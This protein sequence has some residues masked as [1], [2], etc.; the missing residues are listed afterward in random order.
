MISS[1][2][3]TALVTPY[4]ADGSV[5]LGAFAELVS[6]QR[7]QGT[8]GVVVGGSTGESG[9]LERHEFE[10]LLDMALS[11]AR[12]ELWVIAGCGA[13]ATHKALELAR[14]AQRAGAAALLAVTPYYAR[15]TQAGLIRHYQVL[16][17]SS[18]MPTI[19]YNVPGRTGC[20]LL[21]ETAAQ[22][23]SHPLI[24]GIKEA[25]AEPERMQALLA[26]RSAN[27]AVFSGDDPTAT[28]ALLAGADGVISVASNI[29]PRAFRALIDA[30]RGKDVSA[31]QA[32]DAQLAPLYALLAIE[33]NPIPIK[34][35]LAKAGRIRHGLRLP[36][37]ALAAAH[38]GS[39]ER[40]WAR[41]RAAALT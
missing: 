21:P 23:A 36:L 32:L 7:D 29:V 18:G 2:S 3:I 15:P 5:D 39:A 37:L 14:A 12:G 30:A 25:R 38:H 13:P 28:R 19:L 4:N 40:E 35:L 11:R 22:L 10:A 8:Q 24:I 16:A 26:L 20:D 31:A 34:W 6:W 17:E 1:G 9:A 27:F 33:P 41:L